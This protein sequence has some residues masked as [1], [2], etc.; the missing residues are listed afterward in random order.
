[1]SSE[2]HDWTWEP[3]VYLRQSPE[4]I[5]NLK[6]RFKAIVDAAGGSKT[7]VANRM[8]LKIMELVEQDLSVID[9][10]GIIHSGVALKYKDVIDRKAEINRLRVIRDEEFDGDDMAF[11][12][13][14]IA[15]H[16]SELHYLKVTKTT[17]GGLEPVPEWRERMIRWLV[18]GPIS[19]GKIHNTD[20]VKTLATQDGALIEIGDWPRMRAIAS[21]L[22]YTTSKKGWWM[23]PIE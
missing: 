3:P 22:G 10:V 12:E 8:W 13:W 19:D 20:E 15:E 9:C 18:G 2:Q 11:E 6:E 5:N 23:K 14:C 4:E 1:M 21:E 16:V 7:S 17:R